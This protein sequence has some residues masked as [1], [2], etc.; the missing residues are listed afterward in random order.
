MWVQVET[1]ETPC[2]PGKNTTFLH[3]TTPSQEIGA[4]RI[5]TELPLSGIIVLHPSIV[6]DDWTHERPVSIAKKVDVFTPTAVKSKVGS[7]ISFN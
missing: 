5:E 1:L 3:L 2:W 6:C 7:M 4:K